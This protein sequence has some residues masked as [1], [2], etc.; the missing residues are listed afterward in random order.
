MATKA[1]AYMEPG[2]KSGSSAEPARKKARALRYD[3]LTSVLVNLDEHTHGPAKRKRDLN[4]GA[5]STELA[6]LR[7]NVASLK[8]ENERSV[9]RLA[10]ELDRIAERLAALEAQSRRPWWR[11]VFGHSGQEAG[12]A[13]RPKAVA[14]LRALY[15]A[16]PEYRP[17]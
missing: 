7:A 11:R 6:E 13:G 5:P 16:N 9:E 12:L 15:R 14:R 8:A 2:E 3:N 10:N 4:S 1:L 17:T